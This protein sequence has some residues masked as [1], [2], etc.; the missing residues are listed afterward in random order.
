MLITATQKYQRQTPRKLRL[1]ANAVKGFDLKQAF[2]RLS[3]IEKRAATPIIKTLRQAV[4]NAINNHGLKVEDLS[5][6]NIVIETG[7]V[8]KRFRAVSRGRAHGIF[9][10]TGHIRVELWAEPK[11]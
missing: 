5:L 1:V 3:V 9:K 2:E 8:Y 10:R 6:K 7:P 4:A 11:E